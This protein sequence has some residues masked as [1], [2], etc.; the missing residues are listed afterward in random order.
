MALV[1]AED[2]IWKEPVDPIVAAV[3]DGSEQTNSWRGGEYWKRLVLKTEKCFTRY[4]LGKSLY[5][6]RPCTVKEV[7]GYLG[8]VNYYRKHLKN[9]AIVARPL[10]ALT[11]KKI[12]TTQLDWTS[13]CEE[14]F[15]K[16]KE[17]VTLASILLPPDLSKP[18][19]L[20]TDACERGFGAV[21]EQ[22]E[23]DQNC[24]C[25]LADKPCST[26]VCTH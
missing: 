21:L 25:K 17:L 12:P 13:E 14:A 11:R 26:K 3:S 9:L 18:F 2:P 23:D 7:N 8:L 19:F 6:S 24:L 10:T 15:T 20:C 4:D 16:V 5:F 22:E 1:T